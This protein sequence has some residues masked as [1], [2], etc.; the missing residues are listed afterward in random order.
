VA[1]SVEEMWAA[2]TASQ[3]LGIELDEVGDGRARV[4]MTVAG[5]MLN[6]HGICHGGLVFTLADTAFALACNSGEDAAVAAACDVVFVAPAREGDVLVAEASERNRFGRSGV[7]DVS[8]RRGGE[9]I[10]EFRGLSRVVGG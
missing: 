10:A 7:Y 8:V 2:D 5:W 3:R 6:G 1:E 4:R 9:P